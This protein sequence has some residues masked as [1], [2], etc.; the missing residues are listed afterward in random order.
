MDSCFQ[1]DNRDFFVPINPVR[2][3][4]QRFYSV[5]EFERIVNWPRPKLNF[6]LT[7]SEEDD[8]LPS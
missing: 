5:R 6:A 2:G 8:G 3:K 1:F 4:A 7:S